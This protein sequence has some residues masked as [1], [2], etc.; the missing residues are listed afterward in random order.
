MKRKTKKQPAT[1]K[2][3]RQQ[4]EDGVLVY[5]QGGKATADVEFGEVEVKIWNRGIFNNYC[6]AYKKFF[7]NGVHY[8][9]ASSDEKKMTITYLFH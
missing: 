3:N 5:L 8:T 1:K 2:L 6:R 7:M 4:V 9:Q